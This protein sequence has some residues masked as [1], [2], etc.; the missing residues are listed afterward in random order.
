MIVKLLV[1]G[2]NMKPS[3]AVAQ[4]LG[5]MGINMGKVISEINSKTQEFK[6]MKIPVSL[7]VDEKTKDFSISTSSPPTSE[8]IKSELNLEKG[9]SDHKNIIV[10]NAS[11]E[12]LI[13][14]AKIKHPDMLEKD[15]KTAVK[16]ILGT[17]SSVGILVENTK[18]NE[19]MEKLISGKFDSEINQKSI[20]TSPEKRKKLNNYFNEIKSEQ[21]AK[22]EAQK[23]AEEAEKAEAEKKEGEASTET[24]TKTKTETA[25]PPKEDA[26]K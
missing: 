5:P 6:G 14:I 15:F 10:G 26:K 19:L 24:K 18:P 25:E 9:S 20:V 17:A 4:Q 3:P 1:D 8:L 16:S 11:I 2:G 21:D 22:I 23:V 13:K 12:D 7:D